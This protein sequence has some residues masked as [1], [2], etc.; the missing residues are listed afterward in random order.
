MI[1]ESYN[2]R[3][4]AVLKKIA[5]LILAFVLCFALAAPVA[6]APTDSYT[7]VDVQGSSNEYR[8]S[9]EMYVPK[10]EITAS[11][12]GLTDALEGLT[13]I[14]FCPDGT[15][16]VL[17][18]ENSRLIKLNADYTLN[19]VILI[20]DAEGNELNFK[21]AKGVYAESNGDIYIA[22][23]ANSQ[24]V[25]SDNTGKVKKILGLPDSDFIPEGFLYQPTSVARDNEGYT[26]ILSYGCFYGALLYSPTYEFMG[27][28]GANTVKSG[29]LDTL[30]YIWEKLTSNEAKKEASVKTLPYSF[31][32]F[33]FDPEGYLVTC[34]GNTD[35]NAN[36]KGQIRKISPTGADILY[37]RGLDGD[38]TTS[39]SVNFLEDSLV[40]RLER[41]GAYVPQNIV[42]VAVSSDNYIFAL[43]RTNG[44]I[45]IYDNECNLMS[46]FGG[47]IGDGEQLGVF[48]SP[49]ALAVNDTAVLVAD[50]D[51]NA[52][53]VFEPTE[54]GSI[55]RSA[56]NLYLKGDYEEA[57]DLW[58]D[59]LSYD[60]NS[61]L[62]Y[63]GLAMAYYNEGN[64]EDALEAARIAVDY[65][66][67]DLAWQVIVTDSLADNFVWLIL[68]IIAV[69]ALIVFIVYK[70]KKAN[71]RIKN[72]KL[73]I[74][75]QAPFHP[76]QAFEEMKYRKL[77]SNKISIIITILTFIAFALKETAAGFLYTNITPRNYNVIYTLASSAGLILLW[78]VANWL[79][80]SIFSGKG[81]FSEV[82]A[83]T[84]YVLTPLIAYT[85]LYTIA[86]H[87]VPLSSSGLLDGIGT[88]VVIYTLF[89]MC[90]AIIKVHEFDFFKTILTTIVVIFFMILIVFVIFMCAI[91]LKQVGTF[92]YSIYSEIAFR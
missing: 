90:V 19:S 1:I 41:T 26:Y 69:I 44:T 61:Q 13:D 35:S 50:V 48:K 40:L 3:G 87:F 68:I 22:D 85:F 54:Y 82:Y 21:G 43:D 60:R 46:A 53:T 29:A 80:S 71:F 38:T 9:R 31:V 86:S 15:I 23:T 84:T 55:L 4:R 74:L 11:S 66:V 72:P 89:L 17:C 10:L 78:S 24:V 47:G 75:M 6:A 32:D 59:V 18:G 42:S 64:Y 7:R 56:Q 27:F 25:I 76:F 73:K 51:G 33:D 67:Y 34:T 28:Y 91:L 16:L 8:L 79:V 37:K 62:A 45:Y 36:G 52:V 20:T 12:L 5:V 77:A 2:E 92:I 70:A 49:V 14:C 58:T 39:D 65:T 81:T 30:N 88:A 83:A 57:K 63:R